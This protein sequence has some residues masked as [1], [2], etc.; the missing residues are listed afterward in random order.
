MSKPGGALRGARSGS[1]SASERAREDID[2]E[3]AEE[4]GRRRA[5]SGF[6]FKAALTRI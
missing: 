5:G 1:P 6:M 3:D 4:S 2:A